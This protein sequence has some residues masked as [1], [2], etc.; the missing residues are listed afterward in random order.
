MDA[1]WPL[2][3]RDDIPLAARAVLRMTFDTRYILA[4]DV[5]RAID[6]IAIFLHAYQDVIDPVGANHWPAYATV[7]VTQWKDKPEAFGVHQTSVSQNTWQ[8]PFDEDADKY[9][10]FDW[11]TAASVYDKT[12]R[13]A[14]REEDATP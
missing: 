11:T 6:D 13:R 1:I 10:P 14:D 8:G 7:L 2:H 3:E 12:L 5:R 9:L 4:A